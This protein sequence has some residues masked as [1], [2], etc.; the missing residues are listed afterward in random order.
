MECS[1]CISKLSVSNNKSV[2]NGIINCSSC[3]F[4]CC[5]SC[6]QNYIVSIDSDPKCMNC[7]KPWSYSYL[8]L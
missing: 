5:R 8:E 7:Y 6:V 3:G 2:I 1:I 4:E